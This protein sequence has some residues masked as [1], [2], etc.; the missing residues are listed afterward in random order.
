MHEISDS[1]KSV[2]KADCSFPD[3]RQRIK[4][5]QQVKP[6]PAPS[7]KELDA[8]ILDCNKILDLSEDVKIGDLPNAPLP[9]P[10]NID[11]MVKTLFEDAGLKIKAEDRRKL[12]A[13]VLKKFPTSI[14]T[15]TLLRTVTRSIYLLM[16]LAMLNVYLC[17]HHTLATYPNTEIKCDNE[18][19]L[20]VRFPEMKALV[21]RAIELTRKSA[22]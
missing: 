20:I 13:E 22:Q 18:F 7:L 11:Q 9:I 19:P 5:A 4:T 16:P 2:E 21:G 14:S 12:E 10:N 8:L 3:Y 17:K 15:E 6:I 1:Q